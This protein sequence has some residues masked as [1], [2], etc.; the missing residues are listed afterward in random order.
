MYE[1]REA[2]EIAYQYTVPG[3]LQVEVHSK[4]KEKGYEKMIKEMC[5]GEQL[6]K[7]KLETSLTS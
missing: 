4:S 7:D 2:V 5:L 3:Q 6:A 1:R